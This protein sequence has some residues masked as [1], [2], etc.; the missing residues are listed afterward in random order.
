MDARMQSRLSFDIWNLEEEKYDY[1]EKRRLYKYCKLQYLWQYIQE[2]YIY[3]E[4]IR[5]I[6]DMNEQNN[7]FE[8]SFYTRFKLD[9]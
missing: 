5:K 2:S 7:L 4:V 6:H 9:E 8:R 3:L 1:H